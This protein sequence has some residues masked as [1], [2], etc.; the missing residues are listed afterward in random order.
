MC[1]LDLISLNLDMEVTN[2]KFPVLFLI[3]F[4]LKS[5]ELFNMNCIFNDVFRLVLFL[6]YP[7]LNQVNYEYLIL[8]TVDFADL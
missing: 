8:I 2:F 3:L 5:H 7:A 4:N 1:H 6:L